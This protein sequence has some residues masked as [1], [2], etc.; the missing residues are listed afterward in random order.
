MSR[1]T[2]VPLAVCLPCFCATHD[3][4][5]LGGCGASPLDWGAGR[6]GRHLFRRLRLEPGQGLSPYPARFFKWSDPAT[7]HKR[8]CDVVSGSISK[9]DRRSPVHVAHRRFPDSFQEPELFLNAIQSLG[10]RVKRTLPELCR[11]VV[12]TPGVFTEVTGMTVSDLRNAP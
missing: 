10:A 5:C 6:R 11:D 4:T 9:A 2:Q 1:Y 7:F 3:L 8:W 12:F